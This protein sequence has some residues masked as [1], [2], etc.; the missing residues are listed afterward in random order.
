MRPDVRRWFERRT[1]AAADW[2]L[3]TLLDAKHRRDT[4][5]L[6]VSVV[7]PALDEARTIGPIVEAI[8]GELVAGCGLVDEL[9]VIDSGSGDGTASVAAAAGA[10]VL[11]HQDVLPELGTRDGKGEA[12]WKSLHATT[13]DVLVF[14]DADLLDFDARFVTG[15]LG[16]LLTD[17][18]VGFVKATYDRALD[19]GATVLPAGGGRV[20]E[21]VARPL[22]DLHWPRLAGFVQ[23]LAGEYAGRR[24]VL[25]RLPFVCGYGVEL[26]MLIDLLDLVGLDALAQVDLGR[27]AH[28]NRDDAALGRM[29]AAIWC[30]ALGRLTSEGRL[31]M[32][33]GPAPALTQ[34]ERADGGYAA[35]TTEVEV[36]ER[37]PMLSVPGYARRRAAAS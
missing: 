30:T 2:P 20:T 33:T 32:T 22:L 24:D 3:A 28:R 1:S 34:F 6:T 35:V 19:T 8:H 15:L 9:V 27:R 12:L 17:P 10:T 13:G 37:P 25:E 29:A 31:S 11:A 21:L 16:P 36:H 4:G 26:A 14:V 18:A 7:L 5:P 23:P